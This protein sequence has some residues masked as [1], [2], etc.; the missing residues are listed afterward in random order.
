MPRR[1]TRTEW[2]LLAVGL[3][4]LAVGLAP[5]VPD[6]DAPSAIL[7]SA[8]EPAVPA[9]VAG[10]GEVTPAMR[11]EIARV[12]D[13]GA[14]LG[15]DAGRASVASLVTTQVRC[16]TFSGQR[17]CLGVGWTQRTEAEVRERVAAAV[18]T[19]ALRTTPLETT[20]DLDVL[21]T[22]RRAAAR[23]EPARVAAERAEL[24]DAAASVAKVWLL[25]HELQGVPLPAGFLDD[26][27]EARAT[28][29]APALGREKRRYPRKAKVM[30]ADRTNAQSHSWWCGPATMQM[31]AWGWRHDREPQRYWADKL[32]T[33][34]DGS[35]VTSIVRL[36]NRKTGYDSRRRAG[37]YVVLDISD[38]GYRRW[39]RLTKKH[40]ADYRAPLVLHPALLSRFYPYLDDDASGHF[41]VGRG[42]KDK[43]NGIEKIG[44][45][46]PW[47]QQAF[48]PSEPFIDR[49]QWRSAYRSYRANLAHPMQNMGV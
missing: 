12:V 27:P 25:R 26:H 11:R 44:F 45:F 41:Q 1:P 34:T 5:L 17:Y 30:R 21:A 2:T 15:P 35:A 4:A 42:Y 18:A 43:R 13:A 19:G 47:N 37:P 9:A 39:F 31:I 24:T 33:T 3:L 8:Q 28:A 20:G 22:L 46:E 48:D 38:L 10:R 40:I 16:A 23:P 36:V 32:G 6:A 14:S 49:V 29:A 7:P